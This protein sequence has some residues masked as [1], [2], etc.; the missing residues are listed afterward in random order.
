M[1]SIIE[2]ADGGISSIRRAVFFIVS[3][4]ACIFCLVYGTNSVKNSFPVMGVIDFI[5]LLVLLGITIFAYRSPASKIPYYTLVILLTTFFFYYFITGGYKGT[6]HLWMVLVPLSAPFFMGW[7][8][9]MTVSLVCLILGAGIIVAGRLYGCFPAVPENATAV[10][11]GSIYIISLIISCTYDFGMLRINRKLSESQGKISSLYHDLVETS[12]DLIWQCDGEGRIV[13]L[14]PAWKDVLGYA[15]NEMLGRTFA[16]FQTPERARKDVEEFKRLIKGP[17]VKGFATVYLHKNGSEVHLVFNAKSM[18]DPDGSFAGMR[19]TAYDITERMKAVEA[20]RE[21]ERTLRAIFNATFQ[22][23]GLLSPEGVLI[24]ANDSALRFA[25]VA[26][27]EAI[28]RPFWE[29]RWWSGD[30]ERVRRLK[31]AIGRCARGEFIRYEVEL[32]G[33]GDNA[34]IV[35]FSLKPV[36]DANNAVTMLVAEARDITE[37]KRVESLIINAQKL[38]S[39]GVLAGG[40]AHDFNNLLTGIFGNIQ[41]A[42]LENGDESMTQHLTT[43]CSAIEHARGLTRQLLTF[44]KGGSPVK[45]IERL[46]SF[47]EGTV[48]FALSGSNTLCRL[49]IPENTWPCD[50]DRNQIEQ[51]IDNVVI[52]AKQAMPDGGTIELSVE[53]VRLTEKHHPILPAGCYVKILIKDHGIGMP[54]EILTKIFDPFFTTQA[55]GHGLGLAMCYSIIKRHNGHIEAE[56][57]AGRG[58]TITIYL[59]AVPGGS[60]ATESDATDVSSY[61]G[62]GAVLIMDDEEVIRK[63]LTAMLKVLGHTTLCV[64]NGEEAIKRLFTDGVDTDGIVA[65]ILD[66]TVPGAMGGKEAIREIRRRNGDI[67]VFVASGYAEDPVLAHPAK[68]GFTASIYKPFSITELAA[69]LRKHL[70]G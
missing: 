37:L 15:A 59:P 25:G 23:M 27:R 64:S 2:P 33:A 65:V 5:T 40:I 50:I 34:A 42:L 16:D 60:A 9:G 13:Q 35:D 29:T 38:E 10:R 69:V 17:P 3:S 57:E 14:N 41:I 30:N 1:K 26:Y 19:G 31:E 18:H 55:K 45:K 58:T 12:Q 39:L 48:K 68:Y 32:R 43:A 6:G 49:N 47:M 54:K 63:T 22:F 24:E 20:L 66:L 67:P 4:L 61:R 62:C 46:A 52:N 7:K 8:H 53:N 51:V 28:N 21:S 36:S 44:S 56:T 11:L 70:E